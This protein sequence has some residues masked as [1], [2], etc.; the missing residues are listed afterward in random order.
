M[1]QVLSLEEEQNTDSEIGSLLKSDTNQ[2]FSD[3]LENKTVIE[4]PL[5]SPIFIKHMHSNH[6]HNFFE[7]NIAWKINR[8]HEKFDKP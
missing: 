4:N 7:S 1:R 2:E 8:A 5:K 3:N 6:N